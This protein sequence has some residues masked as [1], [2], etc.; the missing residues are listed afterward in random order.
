M[1]YNL[2]NEEKKLE[3][4]IERE[5]GDVGIMVT[6]SV[7][8]INIQTDHGCYLVQIAKNNLTISLDGINIPVREILPEEAASTAIAICCDI[9]R[10]LY[11]EIMSKKLFEGEE[12]KR[13]KHQIDGVTKCAYRFN[14]IKLDDETIKLVT[15]VDKLQKSMK[16]MS[17]YLGV[18]SA[19]LT[20]ISKIKFSMGAAKVANDALEKI[21]VFDIEKSK[22]DKLV[23][24]MH[25][26]A[27]K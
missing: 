10:R 2:N 18:A 6:N 1:K 19:A 22:S 8:S 24:L 23:D 21:S 16:R 9:I 3:L 13:L 27:E 17:D 25:Q 14:R 5:Q 7:G 20:T 11:D 26:A 4:T 15:V 12:F